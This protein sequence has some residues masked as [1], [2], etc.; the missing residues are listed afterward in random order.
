MYCGGS[1]ATS[2]PIPIIMYF[3]LRTK[4]IYSILFYKYFFHFRYSIGVSELKLS[5]TIYNIPM[6]FWSDISILF[7]KHHIIIEY[8]LFFDAC[9][10]NAQLCKFLKVK[11][12]VS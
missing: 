4:Y 8:L 3:I 12:I 5:N 11:G 7:F 6:L 10:G 9:N 2:I 1:H